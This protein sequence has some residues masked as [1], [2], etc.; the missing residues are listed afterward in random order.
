MKY[1]HIE[2]YLK[3][4]LDPKAM[5]ELEK[6]ALEDP[7]LAEALEGY[8]S[9]ETSAS[10][11]L[12][13]L[14]KQ[15]EERIARQ[16]ENK[17][18][19]YF[20]WQRLSVAAAA[21]LLFLSAGILF[22]MKADKG[23]RRLTSHKQV[24]VKLTPADSLGLDFE[25]PLDESGKSESLSIAGVAYGRDADLLK[26]PVNTL[27]NDRLGMSRGT[28][29]PNATGGNTVVNDLE[30]DRP[31][32]TLRSTAVPLADSLGRRVNA[33]AEAEQVTGGSLSD[34]AAGR[35]LKLLTGKVISKGK[36]IPLA[37]VSVIP[38]GKQQ[39]TVTNTDG[40]FLLPDSTDTDVRFSSP[41]YV[42][43]VRSVRAGQALTVA[44][45]AERNAEAGSE[46][47]GA[48][49][50]RKFSKP[51]PVPGWL[52]YRQYIKT[53]NRLGTH[54]DRQGT[55]TVSFNV[56]SSGILSDFK[57][58]KGL[59]EACDKEAIRL[60]EEGPAWYPSSGKDISEGRVTIVF[61]K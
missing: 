47:A 5:H 33:M 58:V 1:S 17:N 30:G 37:G 35:G 45:E 55:V 36:S 21:G 10:S 13:I 38:E 60:I 8:S 43:T 49:A 19:F 3:G 12:T 26:R 44:L 20:T 15:L 56:N 39:G 42:T 27:P 4:T 32:A 9:V 41:G 46:M 48:G 50:V 25:S 7:F 24:D 11:Q 18:R 52:K 22:W 23:Q 31:I 57:I 53:N 14:Q 61:G 2:Q 34:V 16:Q 51:E 59:S 6:Q 40:E 28:H 29:A 54:A